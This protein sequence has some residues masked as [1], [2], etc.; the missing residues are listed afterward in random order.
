MSLVQ[1]RWIVLGTAGAI[2]IIAPVW[3]LQPRSPKIVLPPP[4]L[5][6]ELEIAEVGGVETARAAPIFSP[7]RMAGGT[8]AT[9]APEGAVPGLAAAAPQA[10]PVLV[11]LVSRARGK[12][13]AL[14]RRS[15]GQTVTVA[16]GESVDGWRLARIGRDRASFVA[17]GERRE[18]A[19][20][21]SNKVPAAIAPAPPP[22]PLPPSAGTRAPLQIPLPPPQTEPEL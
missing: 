19:L 18:I 10:A 1:G 22:I 13:V 20:D 5:V 15:D 21:F 4:A 8:V 7:S 17:N 14:V 11:G 9:A 6:T 2:A 12:G 3:M 16:P